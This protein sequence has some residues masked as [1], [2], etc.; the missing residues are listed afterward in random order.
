MTAKH[1]QTIEITNKITLVH[2][3]IETTFTHLNAR[4]H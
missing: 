3:F 1:L 2:L 4:N